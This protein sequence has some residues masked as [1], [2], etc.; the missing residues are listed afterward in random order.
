MT[1]RIKIIIMIKRKLRVYYLISKF[2]Y[3]FSLIDVL[4]IIC[5]INIFLI[6]LNYLKRYHVLYS[7][8]FL[9]QTLNTVG[10]FQT[11]YICS[12]NFMMF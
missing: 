3:I 2:Y 10:N 7:I 9:F 6:I 1:L 4:D 8:I 5:M 11:S 12:N